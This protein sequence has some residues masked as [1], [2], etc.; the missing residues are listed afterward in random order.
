MKRIVRMPEKFDLIDLCD[1]FIQRSDLGLKKITDITK[2]QEII[3]KSIESYQ[4]PTMLYG[5]RTEIMFAYIAAILNECCFVK[6]ED[7]GD[8]YL[9]P[10]YDLL[11]PD[12][13]IITRDK[14][15]FFVEVK[16]CHTTKHKHHNF[17]LP[18][19]YVDKILNYCN[20]FS[21]EV[22]FAVYW[23]AWNIWVLFGLEDFDIDG[24]NYT[25]SLETSILKNQM[26]ILGDFELGTLPPLSVKFLIDYPTPIRVKELSEN[27]FISQQVEFRCGGNLI[28][29]SF[30]KKLAFFL[31]Q[32]SNWHQVVIT[33]KDISE[34][35]RTLEYLISPEERISGQDFELLGFMSSMISQKYKLI[36]APK[37]EIEQLSPNIDLAELGFALPKNYSS[38]ELPLW[39][40]RVSSKQ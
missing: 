27:G 5:R 38:K 10:E 40:I 4:S 26:S 6:K 2:I 7:Q 30:E 29:T 39:I 19:K 11:I 20:L 16:N 12:Y 35:K 1:E 14:T 23:S 36:T 25:I 33:Q 17:R 8:L 9:Q 18:K 15:Q 24:N 13:R 3:A 37:G 34:S 22:K 21:L 31:M 28:T 32:F